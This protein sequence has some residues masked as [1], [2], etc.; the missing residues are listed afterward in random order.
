M[1]A[2]FVAVGHH[3]LRITSADG[4]DWSAPQLGKDG[5]VY[6]CCAFGNSRFVAVGS[7]GG[8]NIVASSADGTAWKA[9]SRDAAYSRYFRGLAFGAAAFHAL[10]GD[11]VSVGDSKPFVT[12]SRDGVNWSADERIAGKNILRRAAFGHGLFVA[13]GD[14]GRRSFSDDGKTWTD[15]PGT[16]AVHTLVDVAFG[17]GV[18]AGVGLHGSRTA[19]RDGKTWLP[20]QRGD[21]GEHLNTVIWAGDRFVAVG[22]G[23][24]YISTDGVVWKRY[25]NRDSPT[26][27]AFGNGVFVGSAWKGRLLRSADGI[28]WE[29]VGKVPYHVEAFAWGG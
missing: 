29:A 1:P 22:D 13:V 10:G 4:R 17:N 23:A 9:A 2:Q 21:E 7:Y 19:S 6:R 15:V 18:F 24:T 28:T 5:E 8:S 25:A 20:D 14:R 3:G 11:P 27:V 16:K 26:V 12:T